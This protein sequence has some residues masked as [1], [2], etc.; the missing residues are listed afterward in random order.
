MSHAGAP[1][2]NIGSNPIVRKLE[3]KIQALEKRAQDDERRILEMAQR[4][5]LQGI[6]IK[7]HEAKLALLLRGI[8]ELQREQPAAQFASSFLPPSADPPVVLAPLTPRPAPS[9]PAPTN[10]TL[11]KPGGMSLAKM[12]AILSNLGIRLIRAD[13]ETMTLEPMNAF[14]KENLRELGL[15]PRLFEVEEFVRMKADLA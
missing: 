12:D 3:Q 5:E 15:T 8:K 11:V 9:P 1:A 6:E 7:A 4:I 2:A 13:E 14:G 10:P